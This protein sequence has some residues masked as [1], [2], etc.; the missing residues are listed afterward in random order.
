MYNNKKLNEYIFWSGNQTSI[1]DYF[2]TNAVAAGWV[3][4]KKVS[5]TFY[6]KGYGK[7][8]PATIHYFNKSAASVEGSQ[9]VPLVLKT[10]QLY[11]WSRFRQYLGY[12]PQITDTTTSFFGSGG[13]LDTEYLIG[14]SA[15]FYAAV[16]GNYSNKASGVYLNN[17][18]FSQDTTRNILYAIGN[19]GDII[20]SAN[21]TFTSNDKSVLGWVASG[22]AVKYTYLTLPPEHWE[23]LG[24]KTTEL[25]LHSI[26]TNGETLYISLFYDYENLKLYFYINRGFDTN[27]AVDRQPGRLVSSDNNTNEYFY[28]KTNDIWFP[29]YPSDLYFVADTNSIF[30]CLY[31]EHL[32][33]GAKYPQYVYIGQLD[34]FFNYNGGAVITGTNYNRYTV[35]T[36]ATTAGNS[37]YYVLYEGTWYGK[38]I[39]S[40]VSNKQGYI[41]L[42]T[43]SNYTTAGFNQYSGEIFVTQ[44]VAGVN[45]GLSDNFEY[46]P[47]GTLHNFYKHYGITPSLPMSLTINGDEFWSFPLDTN[48][49]IAFKAVDNA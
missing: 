39:A 22:G 14:K 12:Y 33:L 24:S 18:G 25:Y 23:N 2:E 1:L 37:N 34:K 45:L 20:I 28:I 17:T 6:D 29:E 5:S 3:V 26:T 47:I 27:L 43:P 15:T 13:T 30:F 38:T 40:S 41:D 31:T 36:A 46:K 44:Q 11:N 19:F 4:D 35:S 21:V 49:R 32:S 8:F 48:N 10:Y 9:N 42:V 16:W 7:I